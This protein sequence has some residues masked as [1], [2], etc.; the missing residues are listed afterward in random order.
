VAAHTVK[1]I[2]LPCSN[3]ARKAIP[4]TLNV[5]RFLSPLSATIAAHRSRLRPKGLGVPAS[6]PAWIHAP[7]ID[8][9][10]RA[11]VWERERAIQ[12]T[13]N[14]ARARVLGL[15]VDASVGKRLASIAVVKRLGIFKRVIRK[16]SIGWASTCGV[17]SAELAAIAAALA[18][19]QD[20]LKPQQQLVVFSDSQHA[21]RA[22]QAGNSARIGRALLAK[23]AQ[24]TTSLCRAGMDL[25]FR[26]SPGHSGIIGNK[27]ADEAARTESDR[28]GKPTAPILERV[29]EVS[30]VVR[31]INEDRSKDQTALD[32]TSMPGRYTWKMDQALP[33]KHTLQL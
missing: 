24:S 25:R 7:W 12:V 8:H 15:Y 1:L 10:Y 5:S 22:I 31:L 21:L 33:G 26:W 23:I 9:S 2:S 13:E 27:E 32:T 28:E 18:Y 11:A 14:I 29:R 3:P 4:D 16:D 20:H 17:L 6:D 19:A 30:G